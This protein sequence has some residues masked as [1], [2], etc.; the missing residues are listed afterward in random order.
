MCKWKESSCLEI[1]PSCV[2]QT[3]HMAKLGK[4]L[5]NIC[6][7]SEVLQDLLPAETAISGHTCPRWEDEV[8]TTSAQNEDQGS[9]VGV[10]LLHPTTA[11][12]AGKSQN[13][14]GDSSSLFQGEPLQQQFPKEDYNHLSDTNT[15]S[16][17]RDILRHQRSPQMIHQEPAQITV[18]FRTSSSTGKHR[19]NQPLRVTHI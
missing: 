17:L 2:S 8:R 7:V 3:C 12:S 6:L 18:S 4:E 5:A 9:R 1:K 15:L 11:S 16:V 19:T 14:Q 10:F 13:P